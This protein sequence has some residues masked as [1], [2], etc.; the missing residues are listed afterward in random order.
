[1]K[2]NEYDINEI[3][4]CSDCSY[5]DF[6]AVAALVSNS[7]GINYLEKIG[8]YESQYWNFEFE[9]ISIT[10]HYN[11]YLGIS[12]FPEKKQVPAEIKNQTIIQIF[13]KLNNI[14]VLRNL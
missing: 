5:D 4:V 11:L 14:H 7:L 2:F 6:V 10:I 12:I 13:E 1:M 3:I 8:D 9:G